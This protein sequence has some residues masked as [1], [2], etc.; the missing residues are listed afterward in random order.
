MGYI[1]LVAILAGVGFVASAFLPRFKAG[2]WALSAVL[3]A[4]LTAWNVF[5]VVPTEKVYVERFFGRTVAG[6]YGPGLHVVNPLSS[7][8]DY[9]ALRREFPV[10]TE[11]LAS[12]NNSLQVEVGFATKLNPELA[13]RIQ[14][15]VGRDYFDALVKPAGQTAVR[16]AIAG[17]PWTTAS[18][19]SRGEV[20]IAIQSQFV[21][22]VTEQLRSS[23]LTD[24]EASRAL[25]IMPVQLRQTTP[26]DKVKNAVAEKTAAEQ[27]LDRQKTLTEI[28]AQ[29][30]ERRGNEGQGVANLFNALPQG[31]NAQ[32][33]ATVLMAISDK[34]RA[35]AMLKAVESGQVDT[36]LMNGD[37]AAPAAVSLPEAQ[38]AT[39]AATAQDLAP[40]QPA[41]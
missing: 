31:F 10:E 9:D 25:Q 1:I 13:Y 22:I 34:T 40:T 35:D 17:F 23:G 2:F 8:Q 41:Q 20:Q 32:E 33:I 14:E 36:I 28:A 16:T 30:A 12:D 26:D 6:Y 3:I 38:R 11:A 27:D 5:I 4:L 19:S 15:A 37:T 18:T 21:A 39:P 24:D 7:F 29:E